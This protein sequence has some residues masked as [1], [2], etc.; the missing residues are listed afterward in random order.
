MKKKRKSSSQRQKKPYKSDAKVPASPKE[1]EEGDA[2]S[3]VK[4]RNENEGTN[5]FDG[6]GLGGDGLQDVDEDTIAEPVRVDGED[7][8]VC[9]DGPL[10]IN[11]NTNTFEPNADTAMLDGSDEEKLNEGDGEM[12]TEA[13]EEMLVAPA[14]ITLTVPGERAERLNING[15]VSYGRFHKVLLDTARK[16][17]SLFEPTLEQLKKFKNKKNKKGMSLQEYA[18]A[19]TKKNHEVLYTLYYIITR[20]SADDVKELV[21]EVITSVEFKSIPKRPNQL[22]TDMEVDDDQEEVKRRVNTLHRLFRMFVL[23]QVSIGSKFS[24]LPSY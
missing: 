6:D 18:N 23:K 2:G 21:N 20:L 13:D 24:H 17:S 7:Q 12:P 19:T 3:E 9:F 10:S 5:G 22:A 1:S 8:K 14:Q 11:P 16:N 4:A 15:N